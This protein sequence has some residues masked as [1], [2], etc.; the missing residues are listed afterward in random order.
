MTRPSSQT[1]T[2]CK[3]LKLGQPFVEAVQSK[4]SEK[5]DFL[6]ELLEG[7]I[8]RRDALA[9]ERNIKAACF[10]EVKTLAD[11]DF[12]EVQA[13]TSV[14]MPYFTECEFVND[15][16]N[17][18]LYGKPGTGKTHL[19]IALGIEACKLLKKVAFYR[20]PDLIQALRTASANN[21]AKF[22]KRLAKLDLIILDEFGYPPR[23]PD[24]IQLFFN[25]ITDYCY[26]KKSL[27]LT[28]NRTIKEWLSDFTDPRDEKM[29]QAAIDRLAQDTLLFTFLGESHRVLQSKMTSPVV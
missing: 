10:P 7:E 13:P 20:M 11:F 25:F 1:V 22:R 19:A 28:S 18:F 3:R 6:I 4:K 9:I 14:A 5:R 17:L 26:E 24:T 8:D 16:Y 15:R 2:W 12:A 29:A 23:D 21:D 27:I